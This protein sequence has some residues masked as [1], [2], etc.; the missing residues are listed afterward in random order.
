[1]PKRDFLSPRQP[2]RAYFP[3]PAFTHTLAARQYADQKASL[4]PQQSLGLR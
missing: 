2:G 1:M 4:A 3:H